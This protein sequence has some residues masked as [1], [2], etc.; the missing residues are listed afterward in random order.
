MWLIYLSFKERMTLFSGGIQ[1]D[2]K[3]SLGP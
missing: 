3:T 1:A 2:A